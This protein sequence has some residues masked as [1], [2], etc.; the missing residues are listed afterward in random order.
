MSRD[1]VQ[2]LAACGIDWFDYVNIMECADWV[3]HK[4]SCRDELGASDEYLDELAAKVRETWPS[5]KT[6]VTSFLNWRLHM[7]T[8]ELTDEQA[9]ELMDELLDRIVYMT[10][11]INRAD[12][13]EKI[14][15]Q[16]KRHVLSEIHYL[17]EIA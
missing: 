17:L 4:A 1:Y 5:C 14:E 8:I 13:V 10:G 3:L 6:C 9:N 15:L 2:E 12:P 7:P 16:H 11:E